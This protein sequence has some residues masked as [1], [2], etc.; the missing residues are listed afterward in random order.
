MYLNQCSGVHRVL[1]GGLTPSVRFL[2]PAI[3]QNRGGLDLKGDDID[4]TRG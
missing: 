4:K 1:P 3:N 2:T